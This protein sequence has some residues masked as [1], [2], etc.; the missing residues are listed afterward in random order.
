M[1]FEYKIAKKLVGRRE[2][3]FTHII[4]RIS[5]WAIA[6]SIAVMILASAIIAGFKK[7]IRENLFGFW[8]HIHIS[9]TNVNRNFEFKPIDYSNPVFDRISDI[10]GVEYYEELEFLG[11]RFPNKQ[12]LKKSK[13]GVKYVQPSLIIPGLI[14]SVDYFQ[15]I[16]FKGVD[17]RYDFERLGRFLTEGS[18][19]SISQ[20]TATSEIVISKVIADRLKLKLGDRIILS[21]VH[22]NNR[23]KRRFDISGIYNTGLE[24]YDK[25]FVIGDMAR[26][27]DF[28]GLHSDECTAVEIVL[29]D[30]R[31][32]DL[33]ADYIYYEVLPSDLYAETIREKFKSI[34]DWLQLQDINEK[35]IIQ[36][37]AVV[38]IINMITVLLILILEK[39]EFIAVLKS[40]GATN[41]QVRKIFLYNAMFLILKGLFL[42]NIF[43]LGI[44]IAQQKFKL[45]PLDE[46]SYY[47]STVPIYINFWSILLI[48][49]ITFLVIIL[50]VIIPTALV[51]GIT[52]VKALRFR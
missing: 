22:D 41:W 3:N 13:G 10:D 37:M 29:D 48:N 45:L 4:I 46:S 16:L 14:E 35:I 26:V 38:A 15:A 43:G 39:T 40:L 33:I 1:S 25:R 12:V 7:E 27:Q 20:D 28:L 34:F 32:M 9:D 31:D 42:G 24:E 49:F 30:M 47:L 18:F 19:P 5:V 44:A 2:N 11:I 51:S 17:G 52:P 36:L 6:L 21:F 8:G 23:I 50:S